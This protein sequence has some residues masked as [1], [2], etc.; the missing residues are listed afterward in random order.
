[1]TKSNGYNALAKSFHWLVLILL[2]AQLI[3]IWVA[4]TALK[5]GEHH[6]PFAINMI[7]FHK[8]LG[9]IVFIVAS[10]RLVWRW[11]GGLPE[12]APGLADCE[13]IA[14]HAI[15]NW[16]YRFL[17]LIPVSGLLYSV[18]SGHPTAVFGLFDIPAL[19]ERSVLLSNGFYLIH[20]ISMYV[21]IAVFAVHLAMVLRRSIFEEDQFIRRMFAAR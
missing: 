3:S 10:A 11:V 19:A 17:F 2:V 20:M 15:E 18:T 9:L 8:S 14:A 16:L 12:W 13:K 4:Q 7:A 21:F 5:S 1:M 6:L